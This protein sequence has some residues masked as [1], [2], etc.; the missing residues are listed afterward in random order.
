MKEVQE[1]PRLVI[2]YKKKSLNSVRAF[3]K[4]K[5]CLTPMTQ[6]TELRVSKL[7]CQSE[8]EF[9]GVPLKPGHLGDEP[10]MCRL[11]DLTIAIRAEK[12]KFNT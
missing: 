10:E 1:N 9:D 6:V 12:Q 11:S 4:K 7:K 2:P 3:K 5:R 8:G